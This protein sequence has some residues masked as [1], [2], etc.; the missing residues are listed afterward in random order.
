VAAAP[1]KLQLSF[2]KLVKLH[3]FEHVRLYS[4]FVGITKNTPI[5]IYYSAKIKKALQDDLSRE[6]R[7]PVRFIPGKAHLGEELAKDDKEEHDE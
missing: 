1:L 5:A 3:F 2:L 7:E 4:V 6:N